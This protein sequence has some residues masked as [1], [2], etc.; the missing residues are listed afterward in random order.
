MYTFLSEQS[1]KWQAKMGEFDPFACADW[2][3]QKL[4]QSNLQKFHENLTKKYT[5]YNLIL[6]HFSRFCCK[7]GPYARIDISPEMLLLVEEKFPKNN[8]RVLSEMRFLIKNMPKSCFSCNFH[9]KFHFSLNVFVLGIANS[10]CN[11][12]YPRGEMSP[13]INF[14]QFEKITTKTMKY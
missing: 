2:Y 9:Q 14:H 4:F 12:M 6:K 7:T 11:V 8:F 13:P 3:K 1:E 10:I 5:K